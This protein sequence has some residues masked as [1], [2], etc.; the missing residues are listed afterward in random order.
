MSTTERNMDQATFLSTK[1]SHY[2]VFGWHL[3]TY[4]LCLQSPR[5]NSPLQPEALII[6]FQS[7]QTHMQPLGL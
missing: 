7:L 6:V 5:A 4:F 2:L 3:G 1:N